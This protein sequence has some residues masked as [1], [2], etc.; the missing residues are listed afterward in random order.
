MQVYR[1]DHDDIRRQNGLDAYVFVRYLRMMVYILLPMWFISWAV[2][3]PVNAIRSPVGATGLDRFTMGN[4]AKNEQH[5]YAAHLILAY[6]FTFWILWV[7]KGEMRHF[8]TVRQRHLIDPAHAN[9]S[10]ASTILVTGVPP[11]YLQ[12]ASLKSMYS[13]LP[14]GVKKVWV[15]RDMKDLPDLYDERMKA[16]NKLEG[17]ETSLLSTAAKLEAK[18]Q[19]AIAKG[20]TPKEVDTTDRRENVDPEQP[21]T[22]AEKL[23]PKKKR[24]THRLGFLPFTGQKVDTIDWCRDEIIRL[25][26]EVE[27][28]QRVC[29][30]EMAL[31]KVIR[32]EHDEQ[33]PRMNSA[34]VQFNNQI[35]AHLAAQALA[36]HEP[37]RMGDKF[38]DIAP[39]DIIWSNLNMNPYESKIRT[40]ISYA[41]TAALV[42]F[43]AIPVAFVGAVSNITALCAK[44]AWLHWICTLPSVVVGIIS[45]LLPPVLLAVLMMLLPIVLRSMSF[46]CTN[47]NTRPKSLTLFPLRLV[48]AKFEGIPR[49][50]SVELSLMTRYFIFQVIHSF[51]VVS[52]AS[53][54]IASLAPLLKD[55]SKAPTL[56][57]TNLPGASIF[58]LTYILLQLSGVAGGFLQIVPLIIYYVKLFL[59]GSTPRSVYAIKNGMRNVQWGTLFPTIT[60]LTVVTL[61]YSVIQPII[62]GMACAIFFLLYQ[63]YKYLFL[64]QLDQPASGDTGG[65]FFP[66]AI[67]HVF[68]GLYVEQ[69]CLC[70]LFFLQQNQH[71][72]AS[73][74]PEGALMVVLIVITAGYHM[75]LND[76]YGPLLTALPLSLVDRES[77]DDVNNSPRSSEDGAKAP[78][79]EKNGQASGDDMTRSRSSH[80]QRRKPV[81]ASEEHELSEINNDNSGNQQ[82]EREERYGG[83]ADFTHPAL[84]PARIIWLPTDSLGLGAEEA[85]DIS[86]R[87]IDVSM[88]GANMNEKGTVDVDTYPPG[89]KPREG[90]I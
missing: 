81:Q 29:T 72:K 40:A 5:R 77:Q 56:L 52:L 85:R 54:I 14:G 62:N 44:Y 47:L 82:T 3:M 42:I 22:L 49:H 45:G 71:N 35:A 76:S 86:A 27:E 70:A 57:A 9:S 63:L 74:L 58:F 1:L 39:E 16:I 4:V 23:V 50:T 89:E 21:L 32:G 20:K 64:Y 31:D 12:P 17:A 15:N 43:W 53:G 80:S 10:Q 84:Q 13:V 24:P 55:P 79:R 61:A 59:L 75:I 30:E 65:L 2:L 36:H 51:L 33:Y 26:K 18:R 67:T 19:K 38:T 83:L 73:C 7:I 48:F 88:R 41:A 8:I 78:L 37:Y 87:G 28:R 66:K 6:L 25:N 68:V 46:F 11:R 60:L 69:I 34:F 90:G